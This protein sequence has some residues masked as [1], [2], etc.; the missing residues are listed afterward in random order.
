MNKA[1]NRVAVSTKGE[2][3][4]PWFMIFSSRGETVCVHVRIH[5][6]LATVWADP[7]RGDILPNQ[8]AHAAA[9]AAPVTSAAVYTAASLYSLVLLIER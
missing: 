3:N 9:A 4:E 2:T 1:K 8:P 7:N 5:A 6:R